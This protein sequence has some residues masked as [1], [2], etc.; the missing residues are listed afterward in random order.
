MKILLHI[1]DNYGQ[2]DIN[3]EFTKEYVVEYWAMYVSD[4][5]SGRFHKD[6]YNTYDLDSCRYKFVRIFFRSY[7]QFNKNIKPYIK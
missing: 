2:F 5:D 4:E 1:E 3:V 6:D 7:T